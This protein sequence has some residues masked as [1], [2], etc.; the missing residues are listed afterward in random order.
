[1]HTLFGSIVQSVIRLMIFCVPRIPDVPSLD[2]IADFGYN[3]W[4]MIVNRRVH[5]DEN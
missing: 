3:I 2:K 1:M 4:H 5:Y